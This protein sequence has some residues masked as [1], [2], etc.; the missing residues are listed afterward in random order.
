MYNY[1]LFI[2]NLGLFQKAINLPSNTLLCPL[3]FFSIYVSACYT[4]QSF[5]SNLPSQ[6]TLT[7][8]QTISSTISLTILY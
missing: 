1:F 8:Y 6:L 7:I 5:F 4:I 3:K 2:S